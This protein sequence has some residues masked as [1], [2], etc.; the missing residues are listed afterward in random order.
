MDRET[1]TQRIEKRLNI[2]SESKPELRPCE[3]YR[4]LV[5]SNK[6]HPSLRTVYRWVD[7]FKNGKQNVNDL[8]RSGHPV[9]KKTI[10][11][12]NRVANMVNKNPN[13]TLK[14]I[15]KKVSVS[16]GCLHQ[17]LNDCLKKKKTNK[18]WQ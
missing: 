10:A 3:I 7:R 11:N 18:I 12:I 14:Q 4:A 8:P 15:K 1:L 6:K 2:L 17:I 5:R 9:S 13:L 16:I